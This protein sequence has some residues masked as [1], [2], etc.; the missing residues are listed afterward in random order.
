MEIIAEE[1]LA[2]TLARAVANAMYTSDD[3]RIDA[4][5]ADDDHPMHFGRVNVMTH[6]VS[7][8]IND[9]TRK[10]LDEVL[11]QFGLECDTISNRPY[12]LIIDVWEQGRGEEDVPE[13]VK[14]KK[15]IAEAWEATELSQSQFAYLLESEAELYEEAPEMAANKERFR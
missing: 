6:D 14:V 15:A 3:T 13:D 12:G 10:N 2:E 9:Q 7:V 1:N 11:D 4:E 8:R 5:I